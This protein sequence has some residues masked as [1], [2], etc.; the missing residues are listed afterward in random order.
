MARPKR[1]DLPFTL[2]HVMSR[3]ISGETAFKGAGD[4][5]KFLFYLQKYVF[6]FDFRVHVYCLLPNHFHLLLE[7]GKKASL[8]E[9]MRRL[10]TAYTVYFNRKHARHGHLFQGRF[11]SLVVD[12][13][14]YLLPLS[15]Y[16][17]SNPS[18]LKK[19]VDPESYKWSSLH[20]YLKGGEPTYLHT[21]EVL[22]WF[23]GGRKQY[24]RFVKKGLSEDIK[25]GIIQ[26]R[27]VGNEAFVKR[28]LG[29]LAQ[30]E[31]RG[32]RAAAAENKAIRK[33][34]EE[35]DEQAKAIVRLVAEE[36]GYT[37]E[38]LLNRRKQKGV[39]G[40]ARTVLAN[41]LRDHIPWTCKEIARFMNLKNYTTI[42]HHL[43][44]IR[45]NK[46]LD[47]I[48]KKIGKKWNPQS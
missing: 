46:D 20:Y 43:E 36:Y 7:S 2:Y 13:A 24:A 23:R 28:W 10:L 26:Q 21:G 30:S 15:S 19:Q 32:A 48:Y 6:L 12:K 8:S 31:K 17:H 34:K 1:I 29:R 47:A 38:T 3:T 39:L 41:L 14:D 40:D 22:G 9:L 5:L 16:I 27:F 25:P 42:Y 4:Y 18:R 35:V 33:N 44:K 11:K 45:E 37:P